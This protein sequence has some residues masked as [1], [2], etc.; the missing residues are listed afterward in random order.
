LGIVMIVLLPFFIIST[1]TALVG[2]IFALME[3][4]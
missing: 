2:P 1:Y 4:N 3:Y